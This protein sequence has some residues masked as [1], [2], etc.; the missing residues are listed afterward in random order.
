[1][2]LCAIYQTHAPLSPPPVIDGGGDGDGV[3]DGEGYGTGS[4]R[5]VERRG[6]EGREPGNPP[7]R[8]RR[9]SSVED[10]RDRVASTGNQQH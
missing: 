9:S 4:R 10:M 3:D 2:R 7:H 8:D 6:K 5:R 1:M